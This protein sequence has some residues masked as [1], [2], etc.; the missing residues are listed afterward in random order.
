ME[1]F[2]FT[3]TFTSSAYNAFVWTLGTFRAGSASYNM[4]AGSHSNLNP[5]ST[6]YVYFDRRSPKGWRVSKTQADA[7]ASDSVLVAMVFTQ[8][9]TESGCVIA[10]LVGQSSYRGSNID[11]GLDDIEDGAVYGRAK[12]AALLDGI[13]LLSECSDVNITAPADGAVLYWNDGAREWQDGASYADADAVAAVEAAGLAMAANIEPDGDGT[14]Y[15]GTTNNRFNYFH[16]KNLRLRS[17]VVA[18]ALD[19]QGPDATVG[20]TLKDS[21]W[22]EQYGHYWD[23]GAAASKWVSFA[24]QTKVSNVAPNWRLAVWKDS[25]GGPIDELFSIDENG[26]VVVDG[27]VDGVDIADHAA[28]VNAHIDNLT[29]IPTRAHSALTGV[30]SDLHHAQVHTLGSHTNRFHTE[31]TNVLANQHH[32]QSHDHSAAGDGSTINPVVFLA[33]NTSSVVEGALWWA[34]AGPDTSMVLYV[35]GSASS[36]Y[37]NMTKV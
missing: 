37:V 17:D 14:R 3:G 20:V 4:P 5:S 7:H 18:M 16:A 15:V 10:P 27:T 24:L 35:R 2:S 11:V 31:L 25:Q 36:W 34:E 12:L 6:Y 13:P 30:T 8:T 28:D 19:M 26:N 21:N 29:D 9:E 22:I 1:Q 32:T 33:P 23:A